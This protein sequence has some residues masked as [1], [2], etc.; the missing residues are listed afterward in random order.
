MYHVLWYLSVLQEKVSNTHTMADKVFVS[1]LTLRS[2]L[3]V[4]PTAV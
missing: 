4:W 3:S 1:L 2:L